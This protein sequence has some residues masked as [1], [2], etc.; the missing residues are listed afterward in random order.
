MA[1]TASLKDRIRTAVERNDWLSFERLQST[2]PEI[3]GPQVLQ[4]RKNLFC[5]LC[6]R[7]RPSRS[8]R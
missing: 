2:I 1:D 4:W 7:K 3:A 6:Q 5:G 8:G